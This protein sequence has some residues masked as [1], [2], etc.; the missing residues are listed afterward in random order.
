MLRFPIN[1]L[2]KFAQILLESKTKIHKHYPYV[3]IVGN[4]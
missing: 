3:N 4:S 1:L 2:T